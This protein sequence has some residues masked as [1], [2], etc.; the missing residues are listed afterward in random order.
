MEGT[1][2][3]GTRIGATPIGRT[4]VKGTAIRGTHIQGT[5][6]G[7]TPIKGTLVGGTSIE[8]TLMKGTLEVLPWEV[9]SSEVHSSSVVCPLDVPPSKVQGSAKL[10]MKL[11]L[12][13]CG[14]KPLFSAKLDKPMWFFCLNSE[15][16]ANIH[17]H[18]LCFSTFSKKIVYQLLKFY[19][20][21]KFKFF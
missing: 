16:A 15:K 10:Q 20:F 17:Q 3:E 18:P 1:L 7:G 12:E 9:H 19:T 2:I 21:F 11:K 13:T 4:K 8:D 14:L 6:I 5:P